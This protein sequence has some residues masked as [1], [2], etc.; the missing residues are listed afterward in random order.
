M[1]RFPKLTETFV[2]NEI[3]AVERLG[4]DI[5]IYPLLRERDSLLQ[6]GAAELAMRAHYAPF[7]SRSIFASQ[8]GFLLRRPRAYLRSLVDLVRDNLGRPRFLAAGLLLFPKV[9]HAAGLMARANIDHVHCHFARHPALA[10]LIISRLTGIPFSFTAHGSDVH[11]DRHM[12]CRKLAEA[13]FAVAIAEYN[14]SVIESE[15]GSSPSG[16][17]RVLHCGVDTSVFAPLNAVPTSGSDRLRIVCVGTLHE[18]KGQVH[19]IEA[20]ALLRDMGI[21]VTCRFVG[22]GPD[23]PSLRR[24]VQSLALEGSVVLV[25]ALAREAVIQEL[26]RADVLVAPSIISARGQ[27]EGIPVVLME[28]MSCGLPVVSSRLSGIPEL[29]DHDRNGLLVTPG[30]ARELA[31]ALA[32]LANDPALRHRLGTAGRR[33]IERDFDLDANA[34]RLVAM[35]EESVAA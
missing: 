33:T 5:E 7:M 8:S 17:L 31:E 12:L 11:V 1:S 25:G 13:A 29:V 26:R 28:A 34:A 20:C 22:R 24:A 3:L 32:R 18:V 14:R 16:K 15:C 27:R 2:L 6:P 23:E 4:I 9:V 21:N 30:S 19:L 35:F 10:G